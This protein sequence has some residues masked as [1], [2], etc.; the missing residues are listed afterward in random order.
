MVGF[1]VL[2]F[3]V[4]A[5][6]I[7]LPVLFLKLAFGLV[8]GLIALAFRILGLG[9]KAFFGVVGAAF[10]AVGS[11]LGAVGAIAGLF[12][13]LLAVPL[14]LLAIPLLPLILLVGFVWVVAKA[15]ETKGVA[16]A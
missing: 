13:A 5:V 8:G 12:I 10:G 4:F 1:L 7:V 9:L 15:F 6:F 16:R 3:M 14:V 11:L 2:C